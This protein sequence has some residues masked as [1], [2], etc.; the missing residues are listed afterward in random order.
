[1][2]FNIIER[3]VGITVDHMSIAYLLNCWQA[4][5]N[6]TPHTVLKIRKEAS[7]MHNSWSAYPCITMLYMSG[8]HIWLVLRPT[9]TNIPAL[10]PLACL[11]RTVNKCVL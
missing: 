4:F 11:Q 6:M 3:P 7:S 1:M 9:Q 8:M 10:A 5:F 2:L